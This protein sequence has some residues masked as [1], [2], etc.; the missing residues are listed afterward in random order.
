[1]IVVV[2]PLL[3]LGLIRLHRQYER[4]GDLL[5]TGAVEASEAPIL[6]R[7]VVVV[8]VDRLDMATAR[9]IQYARTLTPDDLR[10]VHFD[11]DSKEARELEEE[12]GR[13]G[14]GP[15]PARHHRVPRPAAGPG[16]HRAGGRRHPRRRHRVHRPAA[17]PRLRPGVAALPARPHGRQDRRRPLPGA[18]RGA[19]I[20][21]Y[22]LPGP[23]RRAGAPLRPVGA[24]G[25]G[26]TDAAA[27]RRTL[28]PIDA[29]GRRAW[30][31]RRRRRHPQGGP[32]Q[33]TAVSRGRRCAGPPGRGHHAH[34]RRRVPPA[35][36]GGRPGQVGAGAAPGR[37]L[38]PRVRAERRN[39]RPAAGL[40]GPAAR[41]PGSSRAPAWWPRA[42]SEPGAGGRPCSTPHFE[43]V[44]GA[45]RTPAGD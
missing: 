18:P 17:P 37:H 38:E 44:A 6:R 34:R 45:D 19:T 29:E 25:P 3:Y 42:W 26:S 35:G 2:G 20:I 5:E 32:A 12:W 41:S 11:I 22:N 13:L 28:P 16:R 8:L 10:A 43:L 36:Q 27:R 4:G 7:H 33:A 15:A 1:M 14:S 40:P 31:G 21:P 30:T 23:V 39:G 24:A 9:A